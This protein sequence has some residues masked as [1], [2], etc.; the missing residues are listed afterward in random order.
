MF[1]VGLT[2]LTPSAEPRPPAAVCGAVLWD[3][4][5]PRLEA[6]P[7][8]RD[9]REAVVVTDDN[10]HRH[11]ER[12]LGVEEAEVEAAER[13]AEPVGSA[14]GARCAGTRDLP[15]AEGED[16]A[17]GVPRRPIRQHLPVVRRL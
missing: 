6:R 7:R 14:R 15:D 11:A 4:E 17:R 12:V 13:E 1:F 2:A 10:R 16:A 3:G 9:A 5:V 8:Q